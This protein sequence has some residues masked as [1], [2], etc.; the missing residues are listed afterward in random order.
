MGDTFAKITTQ[1]SV[2]DTNHCLWMVAQLYVIVSQVK[3]RNV[4]FVGPK[5]VL[6]PHFCFCQSILF[7]NTHTDY[8]T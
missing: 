4:D 5:S 8:Y 2:S 6:F 3:E 1:L 7:R